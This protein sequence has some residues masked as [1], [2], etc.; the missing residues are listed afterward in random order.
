MSELSNKTIISS[1][2]AA[3]ANGEKADKAGKELSVA[4]WDFVRPLY[5]KDDPAEG[6]KELAADEASPST[7]AT[8]E[9][10]IALLSDH[11]RENTEAANQLQHILEKRGGL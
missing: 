4:V 7:P 11:L 8:V 3:I 10:I 1:A 9:K 5:L 6:A 2:A